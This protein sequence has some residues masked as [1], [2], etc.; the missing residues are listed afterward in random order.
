MNRIYNWY[1]GLSKQIRDSII[2][3]TTIVGTLSTVLSIFGISL[4]D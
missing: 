4:G 1:N 3:S 2:I